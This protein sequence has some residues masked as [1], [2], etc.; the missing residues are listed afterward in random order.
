M[1]DS[2]KVVDLQSQVNALKN[3]VVTLK[4]HLN[5]ARQ[6]VNQYKNIADSSEKQMSECNETAQQLKSQYEDLKVTSE[7]NEKQLVAKI[8]GLESQLKD[9]ETQT[10]QGRQ[11]LEGGAASVQHLERTIA[12][13]NEQ[14]QDA[15]NRQSQMEQSM[16]EQAIQLQ[17]VQNRY[18]TELVSHAE[19]A[20]VMGELRDT[21]KT[22]DTKITELEQSKMAAEGTLKD[23]V[24]DAKATETTLRTQYASLQEQF[25]TVEKENALLHE[26]LSNVTTQMASLHDKS[27]DK[28]H[29]TSASALNLSQSFSENEAKSMDQLMELIK[30]LRKEKGILAG[31]LEVAQTESIRMKAQCESI[32]NQL[33]ETQNA[34]NNAQTRANQELLPSAKYSQLLERAQ[35][36]PALNDSN[37]ILREERDGLKAK[38]LDCETKLREHQTILEPMQEKLKAL[39]ENEDKSNAELA[40]LKADNKVWRDRAKQLIEKHQKISPEEMMKLQ[41]ENNGLKTKINQLSN[42]FKNINAK[43]VESNRLKTGLDAQ[44]KVKL[45]EIVTL[46]QNLQSAK[47]T[48]QQVG[49]KFNQEKAKVSELEANQQKL[50]AEKEAIKQEHA[51]AIKQVEDKN[52]ANLKTLTDKIS[53][54]E[55]SAQSKKQIE[56][57]LKQLGRTLKEKVEKLEQENK[58]KEA[59]NNQLNDELKKAKE[60]AEGKAFYYFFV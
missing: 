29:D 1:V 23:T 47:I 44:L 55:S 34:L 35:T 48:S 15:H 5:K 26:Q 9:L 6:N 50:V 52:T 27:G 49:Q 13:L 38:L 22:N 28:G 19:T 8:E 36:I 12:S 40:A 57:K 30:Y 33:K 37:R 3:E 45:S 25:G 41:N 31:Q 60:S 54:L 59:Q 53:Q 18:E 46:N 51:N 11:A 43:L 56:L 42:E 32:Q 14:L 24:K 39:Q 16:G 10:Y 4:E 2:E 58:E 21:I 20:K 17:T 7:N